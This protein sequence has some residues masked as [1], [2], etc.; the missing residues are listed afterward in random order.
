MP[1]L[2]ISDAN[3]LIDMECGGLLGRM[4]QL[5]FEF[6]VLDILFDE[7]LKDAHPEL[8]D[9]GLTILELSGEGVEQ[10]ARLIAGHQDTGASRNDLLSLSLAIQTRCPLLTGDKLLREVCEAER[11]EV[12]GTLW[13]VDQL[14]A[15]KLVTRVEARNA[16]EAMR[17]Q[18]RRLPWP[19]VT[20]RLRKM[21]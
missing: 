10:A 13:L 3:I 18:G 16:Y 6:A 5:G 2:L 4:F 20:A 7:E 11:H 15:A 9:N 17:I 1:R 19:E 21:R 12:H 8:P 14:Y